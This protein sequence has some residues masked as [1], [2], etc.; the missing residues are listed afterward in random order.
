MRALFLTLVWMLMAGGVSAQ[1][2]GSSSSASAPAKKLPYGVEDV[3]KLSRAGVN[4]DIIIKYVQNTGT[5]YNLGPDTI[6]YLKDQGV[7]DK[8]LG[9]MMDQPKQAG[10]GATSTWTS[11][12]PLQTPPQQ[13]APV[14]VQPPQPDP[15]PPAPAPAPA[16]RSTLHIIPY[17]PAAYDFYY[18]PG[19]PGYRSPLCIALGVRITLRFEPETRIYSEIATF[20]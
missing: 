5:V 9:A 17:Y 6:V 18:Y 12:A 2:V 16:P 7:S 14:Y 11:Q 4:E 15:A 19:W 1:P 13:P 10:S 20:H 8:V 3:L